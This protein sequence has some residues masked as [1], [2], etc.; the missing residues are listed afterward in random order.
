LNRALIPKNANEIRING[1]SIQIKN[2]TDTTR[3]VTKKQTKAKKSSIVL[4]IIPTILIRVFTTKVEATASISKP[5]LYPS[6]IL[7]QGEKKVLSVS[8]TEKKCHKNQNMFPKILNI[9]RNAVE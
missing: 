4:I 7:S 5:F 3:K 9:S 8:G 1:I 2:E 6:P